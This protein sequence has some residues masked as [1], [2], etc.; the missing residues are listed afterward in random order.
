[1]KTRNLAMV[2]VLALCLAGCAQGLPRYRTEALTKFSS[3]RMQGGERAR[4]EEFTSITDALEAGDRLLE[5]NRVSDAEQF[6]LLALRKSELAEQQLAAEKVRQEAQRLKAEED[7]RAA[8]RQR[9]LEE[10]KRRMIEEREREARETRKKVDKPVAVKEKER[11]V[12]HLPSVHTVKRGETLPQIA[13]QSEVYGDALLW[14]LIYRANRD[15]IRDPKRIWPGQVLRIPR[16][17]GRDDIAEARRIAQER[18][19]Q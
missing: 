12:R 7:R 16:N 17:A 11:E 4:A 19:L 18:R 1:M 8:E 5:R 9:I 3:V 10:Q 13:A 14:P 6:Y 15:Q 2:S